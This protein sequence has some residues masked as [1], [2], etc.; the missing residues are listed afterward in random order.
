MKIHYLQAFI[1]LFYVGGVAALPD[2]S[3]SGEFD[4][5]Y[6]TEVFDNRTYV[7][8]WQ[9]GK[10]HGQGSLTFEDGSKYVVSLRT[11][12]ITDQVHLHGQTELNILE[13]LKMM[14]WMGKEPKI[15]VMAVNTQAGIAKTNIVVRVY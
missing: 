10:Q 13:S 14:P 11:Q 7:G 9:D 15:L 4:N 3:V 5:C 2:C 8:D 12:C 1:F 6:G